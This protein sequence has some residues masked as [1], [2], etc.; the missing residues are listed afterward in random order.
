MKYLNP[1]YEC[2]CGRK[3][4]S[5]EGAEQHLKDSHGG[6]G[7]IIPERTK[8][9]LRAEIVRLRAELHERTKNE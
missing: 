6:D 1:K 5:K 7:T 8:A 2:L 9:D 4:S 3:F